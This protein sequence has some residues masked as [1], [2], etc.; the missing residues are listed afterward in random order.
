[1]TSRFLVEYVRGVFVLFTGPLIA[2]SY[3]KVVGT[4]IE[5]RCYKLY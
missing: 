2:A 3:C 5:P 1:M 4:V